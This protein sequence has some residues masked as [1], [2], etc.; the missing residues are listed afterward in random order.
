[1]SKLAVTV[2]LVLGLIAAPLGTTARAESGEPTQSQPVDVAFEL[3]PLSVTMTD[4]E[5]GGKTCTYDL[6]G[7]ARLARPSGGTTLS[8]S[9]SAT[10][11][12]NCNKNVTTS[13]VVTDSAPG[14]TTYRSSCQNTALKSSGCS[15][16]QSVTYFSNGTLVRPVSTV[17][18]RFR[19]VTG[20]KERLCVDYTV[21]MAAGM[22]ASQSI[23]PCSGTSL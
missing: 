16:T 20:L 7:S 13:V 19:L 17:N 10:G 11:T 9:G 22:A 2:I 5:D 15:T 12:T 8:E 18:F 3:P 6:T 23:G 4:L 21:S 14:Q 1:M